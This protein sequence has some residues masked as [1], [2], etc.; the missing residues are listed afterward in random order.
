MLTW[1]TILQPGF[2]ELFFFPVNELW[3]SF[4]VKVGV[5][6]GLITYRNFLPEIGI[7]ILSQACGYVQGTKTLWLR[8]WKGQQNLQSIRQNTLPTQKTRQI[9]V[10]VNFWKSKQEAVVILNWCPAVDSS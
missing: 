9:V 7:H 3:R 5:D 2:C 1:E 10:I 8:L 4:N 6:G